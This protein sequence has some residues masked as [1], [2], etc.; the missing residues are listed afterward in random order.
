MIKLHVPE[1]SDPEK[2][3][4]KKEDFKILVL[5]RGY[6]RKR[7]LKAGSKL[8][9]V[10]LEGETGLKYKPKRRHEMTTEE[11]Q[12]IVDTVKQD[13]LSHAQAAIKFN[14]NKTLI[15]RLIVQSRN[16]PNFLEK[17]AIK[18]SARRLKLRAVLTESKK[19][20]SSPKG[21]LKSSQVSEAVAERH[22][23]SVS[24]KYVSAVLRN[25][26]GARYKR[27]KRIP[28]MGNSVRCQV[29]R[30]KYA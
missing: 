7:D 28:F 22:S 9:K 8:L 2:K 11:L 10:D 13:K 23:I 14:V 19:M 20:L 29:L 17:A 26:L 30:Q 12:T 24:D 21:L 16:D 25:D 15:S 18:E 4:V 27:I 3:A 6:S 1:E 5:N